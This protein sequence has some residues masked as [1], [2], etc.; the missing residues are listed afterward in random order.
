MKRI[1]GSI[2]KKLLFTCILLLV[3]AIL[4]TGAILSNVYTSANISQAGYYSASLVE[5]IAAN[6]NTRTRE[7]EDSILSLIQ[8]G[9][10]FENYFNNPASRSYYNRRNL[11]TLVNTRNTSQSPISEI[12]ILDQTGRV[13]EFCYMTQRFE[14]KSRAVREMLLEKG[15]ELTWRCIWF[16]DKDVPDTVYMARRI[17]NTDSLQAQG[18]VV[19]GIDT[20]IFLSQ[21]SSLQNESYG[22]LLVA[23]NQGQIIFGNTD[24]P[25][26]IDELLA[27]EKLQ[28]TLPT[29]LTFQNGEF[30]FRR[31][32]SSD[33]KWI[34]FYLLSAQDL[35]RQTSETI[36]LIFMVCAAFILLSVICM[37]GIVHN[38]TQGI[39]RLITHLK[40]VR[41]G[42]WEVIA[43]PYPNDEIGE[44]TLAFNE[45]VG[46]LHK[47][48]EQV[49]EQK[50][51][52]ERAQY[53][54]LQAEFQELQAMLNPH[55][56]YNA[57][58][59]MNARAKL[60][61]QPEISR[62]CVVLAKLMRASLGRKSNIITMEQEIAHLQDYL[63]VQ[64]FI[65]GGRLDAFFDLCGGLDQIKIP[66][67]LLQPIVENAIVH[68]VEGQEG[69]AVVFISVSF[70]NRGEKE[71]IAVRISD[72]GV[73]MDKETLTRLRSLTPDSEDPPGHFGL[74]S[75]MRRI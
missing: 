4:T 65:M 59:A 36:A 57:M 28:Y 23:N 34:V 1:F 39:R 68:G 16:V 60:A 54:A 73:G 44:I 63:E 43:P 3:V 58:E 71:C 67:L 25:V 32:D 8:E 2:G 51:L 29:L 18:S 72:N 42:G 69:D 33:G 22:S 55:F 11:A 7:Y 46:D 38:L 49:A 40:L 64:K 53:R 26:S 27:V 66:A 6:L 9:Q 30:L 70:E 52:A 19:V 14:G 21:F 5:Q 61:E 41:H 62:L 31:H 35:S 20:Q 75:V 50:L 48:V 45:M 15:D 47:L 56:I 17:V 24:E 74:V 13:T 12:Y 10:L 37:S